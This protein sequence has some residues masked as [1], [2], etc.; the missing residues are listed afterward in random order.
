MECS[1]QGI[2]CAKLQLYQVR[3]VTCPESVVLDSPLCEGRQSVFSLTGL[4]GVE[5]GVDL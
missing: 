5:L 1:G 4:L 2:K 3:C